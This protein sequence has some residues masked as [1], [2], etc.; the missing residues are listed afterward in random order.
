MSSF[1]S[2]DLIPSIQ[3]TLKKMD[4]SVPTEI[5][6]RTLP[7]LLKGD[8]IAGIAE[9]G[10]G[11][12]LSY[13]MPVLQRI[14]Q[15][16]ETGDAVS[17]AGRPRSVIL[18]PS[19]DLGEQVAKV[20]KLFTHETR[21]RVRTALGG[22]AMS[23]ARK[24]VAAPFEILL[25]TPGRLEQ[26]ME[27][28]LLN[29]SD[30]R[31]LVFDEADQILDQGFL[32][33]VK[34]ILRTC[35]EDRQLAL[36][37]ATASD[38]VRALIEEMFNETQIIETKGRHRLVSTLKTE[39]LV[40]QNGRRFPVLEEV[41][42]KEV[43]GGT[44]MFANTRE[45]CD[46]LAEE[47]LEHGYRCAIYRGDMD[48]LERRANLKNFREGNLEILISTDLASRGLDVEHVDRVINYHLPKEMK[49]YLHRAGRTARAGR[50]GTVINFVTDRDRN[51]IKRLETIRP[52]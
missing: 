9:T 36:F 18:V 49:N 1:K 23:I 41:L 48:K 8:S 37:S 11:K 3:S 6:G 40:I 10:S 26:L 25:A 33:S 42:A 2:F 13:A 50:S 45:Q 38:A 47:L 5:Q 28:G 44:L 46:K 20:F 14:K 16:E 35:P 39:N 32:P 21:L 19:S 12:T 22:T 51:L 17:E 24:N 29:L 27:L 7:A 4:F 34:R 30:V 52:I 43:T 31:F 15:L